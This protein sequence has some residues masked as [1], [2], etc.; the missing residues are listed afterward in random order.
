VKEESSIY[1]FWNWPQ[2]ATMEVDLFQIKV[3]L[4]RFSLGIK[5]SHRGTMG[6]IV[7]TMEAQYLS[8]FFSLLA[9]FLNSLLLQVAS[10]L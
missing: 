2:R 7:A 8:T 9:F 6:V 5:Y 10:Y 3:D 4:L 1:R